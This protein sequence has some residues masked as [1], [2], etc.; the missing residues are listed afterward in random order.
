MKPLKLSLQAF[1]PFATR[2]EVDFTRLPPGALFLIAGPTGAGKTSILDGITYALY[3]DTSGGERSARE[4]RSH[5]A[6]AALQTEVE[7]AFA[8][9]AQR[10]RVRRVPEQT[11]AAQRGGGVVNA[12]AKAELFRLDAN[13]VDWIPLAQRTT[14]VT[15]L[16]EDL[17]GFKADQFRQVVL[18]PQGQF[19]KLLA[20]SSAEREK[21]LETLFGTATYKHLQDALKAEAAALRE[22]GEKAALQRQT[23]LGQA[24]VDTMDALVARRDAL[25][26]QLVTLG[27]AEQQVRTEDTAARAALQH[28]QAVEAQFAEAAA[29]TAALQAL[30]AGKAEL[31]AQRRRLEQAR[32]AMQVQPA[33]TALASARRSADEAVQREAQA[34]R[35]ATEA[36]QRLGQAE[37]TLQAEIAR[38]PAREAAQRELLRLEGLAEAVARLAQAEIE[39]SRCEAARIAADKALA[40]ATATQQTVATRRTTLAS[41]IDA[42]QPL[43]AERAALELRLQQAEQRARALAALATA[44]KQL[45][46]R[47]AEE[48]EARIRHEAAQRAAGEAR[49]KAAALDADW[50]QAQAAIL[51]AHL[52]AGEA[53]PVCGSAAHPAPARHEGELPTEQALQAAAERAR[54]AEAVLDAAR[55]AL[56]LAEL[57]RAT[58]AAEVATRVAELQPADLQPAEGAAPEHPQS[59]VEEGAPATDA[60]ELRRQ[61]DAARA[62]A[63]ELEPLRVQLQA[64]D[65]ELGKAAIAGEQA[66]TQAAEAA[67]AARAAQHVAD[68][69]RAGVP[70]ALRTPDALQAGIAQAQDTRQRLERALQ[71]AQSTQGEAA[72]RAAALRAQHATL[73]EGVQAA[74]ARVVEA[75]RQFVAALQTAGFWPDG[76]SEGDEGA[77]DHAEAAWRAALL[78]AERI[79]MLE[80]A[81]RDADDRRAAAL[82]RAGRA[83]QAVAGLVRPDLATLDARATASRARVEAV[84][85]RIGQTRSELRT[86]TD[87]LARLDEI[88]RESGAIE[89]EYRVVGHLADIANGNNGRNLTFQRYVLAAL[90]DDVLRAASLRLSTMSRGR[91]QLQRREDVADARRA[92]GLDLEVFDEY[93]GRTRP[94]STLSGGEGF[95]ASLSL[96]LGLSDVVQAYAGGVQLDTLFIDEGFGSLDPESLDMAMKA[97]IDLQ[98][99]GR[100]VGVISHVEEM[101]Q[102]I[103]VTIEVVQGVR[104][105]RVKVQA[106]STGC[107]TEGRSRRAYPA[108]ARA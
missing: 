38:A 30:E 49:A 108:S 32:R 3:G 45:A 48:T 69:R 17:L 41:R 94:A 15:A 60:A 71:Q 7:L 105:S 28:G 87:T 55:Q 51:A 107:G 1:G 25:Q 99:R 13:G 65:A 59:I 101:K 103:D 18:L 33:D 89:A 96:A 53:C 23:L 93:T 54:E 26:G 6:D 102:Q 84:V 47:E 2:E 57:A 86:V 22:R 81:V 37:A 66:R 82:E 75:H 52:H 46:G 92:A 11:R 56:N 95:M 34:A 12:P 8:L 36:A 104:G 44:R 10:Y 64:A 35:D 72:S 40:A 39:A 43:A 24:G 14:E 97:L 21:I 58:A 78:P 4:M 19:R 98:Q 62:A 9:G 31:D 83:A 79:A 100:T 67:S 29:A 20:A 88:A 50:R 70:E 76:T 63:L 77:A 85:D 91:Y 16:V 106:R 68:E 90:L 5:H 74:Q 27:D 61:L 80:S 42:L 73:A